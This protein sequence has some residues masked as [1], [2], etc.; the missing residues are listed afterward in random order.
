MGKVDRRG[1]FKAGGV[2][3]AGGLLATVGV[4]SAEAAG[5]VQ[6]T[7]TANYTLQSSDADSIIQFD[8]QGPVTLTIPSTVGPVGMNIEVCQIGPGQVRVVGGGGVI[9]DS[10]ASLS[11][12]VQYST[13]S[14]RKRGSGRWLLSGDST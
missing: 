1:L 5:I 14:L 7:K 11:T 10:S 3:G 4:K 6:V 2:L 8:T 13:L 9:I 12:R